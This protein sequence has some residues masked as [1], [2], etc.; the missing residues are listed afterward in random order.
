MNQK[1][2]YIVLTDTGTLLSRAIGWYTGKE[3]NHASLSFDADLDE[4]YSFGRKEPNNPFIGGFVRENLASDWFLNNP[5]GVNC[6]I[7]R[8][9]VTELAYRRIRQY[10]ASIEA[11]QDR[12]TYNLIGLFGV[13]ANVRIEREHAFFCSQFVSTA[14]AEGGISLAAKPACLTT[15]QDLISSDQLRLVY[16][17]TLL[18]YFSL[19]ESPHW[20]QF[21][22]TDRMESIS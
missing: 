11:T 14:L 15:P 10:I 9:D 2:I 8:C 1:P 13:A 12:Y 19:I 5:R 3:L 17:G 7:F 18:H 16:Q 21:C 4:V 22:Y 6:A 20:L